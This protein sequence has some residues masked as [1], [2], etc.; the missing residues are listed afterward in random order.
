MSI[1]VETLTMSRLAS[2]QLVAERTVAFRFEKPRGWKF[3]AGQFLDMT[4]LDP[5]ETDAAGNTR[6]FSIAIAP[7]EDTLMIA[8]RLRDTAFKRELMKMDLGAAVSIS[9]P[10]GDLVLDNFVDRPVV[11]LAGGIGIT[12][13]RSMVVQAASEKLSRSI[14]LLY[15]NRRPE[16]APF[17]VELQAL[18][19][20]NP[21]YK[22]I[23]TMTRMQR[24]HR[25]WPG[26]VGIIDREMLASHL[27]GADSPIFYIAGPP[28]LVQGLH[29]MLRGIGVADRD[30]RAEEFAGY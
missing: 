3:Q 18:E 6:T 30:I 29:K 8:T 2:R 25:S 7:H 19:R 22:F 9:G 23:A 15:S 21:N 14:F 24:S 5:S 1:A 28:G 12:P 4:L 11:L 26:E 27:K 10:S 20:V 13:F 17:L 16:D